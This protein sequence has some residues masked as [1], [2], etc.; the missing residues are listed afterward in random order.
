MH[1]TLRG[2]SARTTITAATITL[3]AAAAVAPATADARPATAG[4]ENRNLRTVQQLTDCVDAADAYE[5]LEAFQAIADH[6]GGT[7]ASGTPGYDAS[8]DYVAGLLTDAGFEVERQQFTYE[9]FTEEH[10]SLTIDGATPDSDLMEYSG[11]G[12]VTAGTI[13]PVDTALDDPGASTSGCESSDFDGVDLNGDADVVLLQRGA[14]SFF[15]KA[16]NAEAAGAEAVLVFNQGNGEDR[17]GLFLGTL[18]GSGVTIPAFSLDFPTGA[19]LVAD[20]SEDVDL[21]VQ[22]RTEE[23]QTENV[24]ADLPGRNTD[25]VVMAGAHLDSVQEGPGIQDNGSGSAALLAVALELGQNRKY[26][27]TNTLRFAWWGAEESGLIGSNEYV[28]NPDFGLTQEEYE[29]LA[30]YLNFDM[31]ASPNFVYGVYDADES[32]YDAADFGVS[33]PEGSIAL[34]DLFE[35]YYTANDVPYDDSAFSGRSDYS[36]FI[37]V[38][39]PSSGLFTG[40]EVVKTEEQAAIWGGDAGEQ[41]DPCYHLACDDLANVSVEALDVNVDAIADA[42]FR[43]AASTEAVNGVAGD[44]VPGPRQDRID[45]PQGTFTEGGGGGLAPDHHGHDH[46]PY[47]AA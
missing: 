19:A 9:V 10:A 34:E 25:N 40:A 15:A 1:I 5:H 33:V 41:F 32:T 3:V 37:Q 18:G 29:A 22:A 45:G 21:T 17:S 27:P 47:D 35:A 23:T 24:V 43:L 8:V 11:A 39:I 28:F 7:R 38:G 26:T 31:I 14:C 20:P 12:T 36:A 16:S 42:V 46:G 30:L 44:R 4:C 13:V 6:N 2:R